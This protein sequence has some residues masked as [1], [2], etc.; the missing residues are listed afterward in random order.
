MNL[1]IFIFRDEFSDND[2]SDETLMQIDT[3]TKNQ[4]EYVLLYCK[5]VNVS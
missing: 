3:P 2:V 4:A 5:R 1:S